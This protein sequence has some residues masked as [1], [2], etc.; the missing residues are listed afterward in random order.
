MTTTSEHL[1]Q[2]GAE[3]V[4]E[5]FIL[6]AYQV[7]E[8]PFEL[9]PAESRR[10]WMDQTSNRFAYRCLPMLIANQSGWVLKSA[11]RIQA[12]WNGGAGREDTVVQVLGGRGAPSVSSHFGS[13]VL[14]WTIPFLFRTPPGWN[15]LVRGP[16]NQPLDGAQALEGVVEADWTTATFTMNWK[17][18]RPGLS[19]IFPIG[20][21][22]AMLVPTRRGEL[23]SFEPQIT[24]LDVESQVGEH[25]T[26]WAKSRAAFI[27]NQSAREATPK[28][29]RD[30]QREYFRGIEHGQRFEEHQ[31]KLSLEHFVDHTHELAQRPGEGSGEGLAVGPAEGPGEGLAVGPG[32]GLAVGPVEGLAVGPVEGLAEGPA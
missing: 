30:W 16:A 8:R 25:Y 29:K 23:E 20:W 17:L 18:T 6:Q 14:T 10:D 32:E 9:A 12:N 11:H 1:D 31:M 15:L 22:I 3:S 24:T 21:P 13:G 5:P 2:M 27:K 7:A 28:V 4:S 26:T 19:V